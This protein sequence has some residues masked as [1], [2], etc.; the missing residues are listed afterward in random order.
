MTGIIL[1]TRD[2]FA[3]SSLIERLQD[4]SAQ[5][6][7]KTQQEIDQLVS[8]TAS[9][10]SDWRTM[11]SMMVG[12]FGYHLG[13]A[14]FLMAPIH[15]GS[16]GLVKFVGSRWIGTLAPVVGLATE[17]TF[18]EGMK[19]LMNQGPTKPDI[20]VG[21]SFMKA[22]LHSFVN[23]GILK[24][25]GHLIR[26]QNVILQ[27]SVQSLGM[28]AGEQALY[29]MKRGA[30]PEGSLLDQLARAEF[31]NL[32]LGV[33]MS[34]AHHLV[35]G[36]FNGKIKSIQIDTAWRS[37][38]K[39]N[40]SILNLY[41]WTKA[42]EGSFSNSLEEIAIHL[43]S[44]LKSQLTSL[45]GRNG[46]VPSF[47]EQGVFGYF[48]RE[49]IGRT[50]IYTSLILKPLPTEKAKKGTLILIAGSGSNQTAF[51]ELPKDLTEQGWEVKIVV[52]PG[53]E[54]PRNLHHFSNRKISAKQLAQDWEKDLK[55]VVLKLVEKKSGLPIFLGGYSMGG[56]GSVLA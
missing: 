30:Q 40:S 8:G 36:R 19:S 39:E 53:F 29:Q 21:P 5:P 48:L 38:P 15:R 27:H 32:Q 47:S 37:P 12:G 41:G 42:Y 33:S 35:G 13:K 44:A 11:T 49:K 43:N 18:F 55:E 52:I 56:A 25:F 45:T 2:F 1:P 20:L 24:S 7:S 4:E 54:N 51:G 17:V 10:L 34:L 50:H 23:F 31:T 6:L 46:T 26:G 22:W 28:V 16:T 14:T 3:S 9:Q